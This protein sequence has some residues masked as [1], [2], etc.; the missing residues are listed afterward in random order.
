MSIA[1]VFTTFPRLETARLILRQIVPADAPAIFATF[2]DPETMEFYGELP[3]QTEDEARDL[4]QRQQGWYA[5]REGIRWG[6]TRR[7][8][9][10]VIGSCGFFKFDDAGTCA[11]AGYELNRAYWR[12]GIMREAFSAALDCAFTTMGLHRVEAVVDAPNSR[13]QAFLRAL[14]FTHEGTLRQR[15]WF[16]ERF[17][18]E[19]YFGLLRNEWDDHSPA[20]ISLSGA[21]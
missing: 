6:I 4:V 15:F 14:G 11:E 7:G 3:Y 13:S 20:K 10:T 18:D 17:W 1:E 21:G 19:R 16:R 8:D 2:S 9:D 5:Q 12:Q